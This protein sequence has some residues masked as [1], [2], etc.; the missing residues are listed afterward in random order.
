[1]HKVSCIPEK[2]RGAYKQ[3]RRSAPSIFVCVYE[4]VQSWWPYIGLLGKK[5]ND[6]VEELRGAVQGSGVIIRCRAKTIVIM[7]TSE[8]CST[9]GI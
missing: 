5:K 8:E 2:A 9:A 6:M 3:D 4:D 7:S 1:M